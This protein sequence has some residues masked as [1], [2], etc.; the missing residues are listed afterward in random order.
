MDTEKTVIERLSEAMVSDDL[1][2]RHTICDADYVAALG[3]SGIND[4]DGAALLDLDLTLSRGSVADAMEAARRITRSCGAKHRWIMTPPK[5]RKIAEG[6]MRA[7]LKPACSGCRGRGFV[8]LDRDTTEVQRVSVC[9]ACGGTG[10]APLPA[11]YRR[12][13]TEVLARMEQHR[14]EVGARVRKKMRMR[15]DV[16]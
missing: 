11:K 2:H 12:E 3:M 13:I 7:Y 9:H 15:G 5:V 1:S 14:H 10:K 16:E 8:G 6:A 4:R